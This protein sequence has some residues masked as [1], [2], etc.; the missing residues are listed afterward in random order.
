M[1]NHFALKS[2]FLSLIATAVVFFLTAIYSPTARAATT[3][4]VQTT[5]APT[6]LAWYRG[7]WG[8]GRGWNRGWN[9]WGYRNGWY[10]GNRCARVC[11][12][13]RWGNMVCYRRC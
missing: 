6:V 7:G 13:N 11:Y 10:G 2:L 9:G 3:E 1:V 5:N 12:P 4:L 8:W